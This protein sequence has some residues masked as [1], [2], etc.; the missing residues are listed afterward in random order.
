MNAA[1]NN[2]AMPAA[3]ADNAA[4]GT[5]APP[6]RRNPGPSWGYRFLRAADFVLPEFV[7]KPLRALGTLIAMTR[8]PA[9]R[10]HS[11]EYL[12]LVLGRRP[13]W[14]EIFRHFFAFE[15][16]LMGRLRLINGRPYHHVYAGDADTDDM[17]KWMRHGGRIMLGTFH[18]GASDMQAFQ[19][20]A[21]QG[22][23][24]QVFVVRQRVGN[25][26]D[27]EKLLKKF[28]RNL[29][30]IWINEPSEMLYALKDAADQPGA[31]AM[32][33]DRV[34]FSARTAAFQF[35]GARRLFPVTIYNLALIFNRPVILSVGMPAGPALAVLHASPRFDPVEGEP[36]A[37]AMRR[38][39]AHFQ[40][41]LNKLE[42]LLRSD[43]WQWFNFIPLNPAAEEPEAAQK[44]DAAPGATPAGK[45]GR[46]VENPKS[47][48]PNPK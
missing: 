18:V 41:F 35:L 23:A 31:I 13:A 3:A 27:V 5:A 4:T 43:P 26:H 10:R 30:P 12:S 39:H 29:K 16:M 33:C 48:C 17:C 15:E 47:Q 2:T 34:K 8:M 6:E 14:R 25:S 21:Y 9:E 1:A 11:R 40:A 22:A 19:L 32:Q 45:P 37:A 38:A 20:G 44:A 24:R 28:G 46:G 36:R 42:T 7:Y